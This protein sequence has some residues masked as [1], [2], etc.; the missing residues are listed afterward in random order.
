MTY[1]RQ[2]P[3]KTGET[4]TVN[5]HVLMKL[6]VTY[7]KTIFEATGITGRVDICVVLDATLA[8]LERQALLAA[9]TC[10]DSYYF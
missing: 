1:T 3:G 10:L 9:R 2:P 8:I 6:T 7:I 5:I 4:D